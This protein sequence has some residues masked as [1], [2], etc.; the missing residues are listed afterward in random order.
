MSQKYF[1]ETVK[2]ERKTM[3]LTSDIH[4]FFD[5]WRGGFYDKKILI[6]GDSWVTHPFPPFVGNLAHKFNDFNPG[7]YLILNIADPGDEA[8]AIFEAHG[9]QMEEL[10]DLIKTERWGEEFDLIFLSAAG[11]DIVGPEIV[12]KGY[13]RNKSEHPNLTGKELITTKFYDML[14]NVV[15]GYRRFL[16]LRDQGE[17][18]KDTP[19]ITHVYS[20]LIPREVGTHIGPIEFNKGW[21]KIYLKKQNIKDEEEQY[22]II[23]EMLDAFYKRLRI[24]E[25]DYSRFLVVDTRRVLSKGNR[26]DLDLWYNEIHPNAKG[27]K[28]VAKHIRSKARE[29]GLWID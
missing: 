21:I 19:V 14:D 3:T 13:V 2:K 20:Y 7:R 28:K 24:L 25:K 22:E 27:F 29:A 9:K 23:V 8:S 16:D 18:N 17:M 11:N 15:K 6:E 10:K 5:E 4:E 1:L 12:E 26:P